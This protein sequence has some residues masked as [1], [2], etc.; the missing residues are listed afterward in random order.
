MKKYR[1]IFPF[2]PVIGIILT[3]YYHAIYGDTGMEDIRTGYG[4]IFLSSILVQG[5]SLMLIILL[6]ISWL[7]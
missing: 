3:C 2:I 6:I 5:I 1:K 7:G 4:L